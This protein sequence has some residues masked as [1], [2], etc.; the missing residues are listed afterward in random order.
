LSDNP[1]GVENRRIAML[2]DGDNA[3]ASIIGEMLAE[4]GKYGLVTVRRIYGDWTTAN[5]GGWKETLHTY[6]IQPIQQFRYSVGKNATDSAM[7]IDAMDILYTQ[8]V[9]GFCL[10]SSDSDYTRLATRIREN[11]VFVIGIGKKLTPRAFVNACDVFVYAENLLK[12]PPVSVEKSAPKNEPTTDA[13]ASKQK[14]RPELAPEVLPLFKRAFDLA[15]QDDGWAHLGMLGQHLRQ[16]DPSFDP[17][18]YGFKQLSLLVKGHPEIFEVKG[19]GEQGA[20]HIYMR[21]KST[22]KTTARRSRGGKKKSATPSGGTP[23]G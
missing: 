10:V 11:R 15:V 8:R 5:M 13:A 17:R 21:L 7:I 14:S 4:A 18:T 2:I 9:D 12:P 22:E 6:A 1:I 16:L 3:Q 20:S 19:V 23:A